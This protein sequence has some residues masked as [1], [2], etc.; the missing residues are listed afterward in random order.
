MYYIH[1]ELRIDGYRS[2]ARKS[3]TAALERALREQ[4]GVAREHRGSTGEQQG[5]SKRAKGRNRPSCAS[6]ERHVL[7]SMKITIYIYYIHPELRI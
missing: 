4:G 6:T 2:R 7:L 3:S 5:S 1:P